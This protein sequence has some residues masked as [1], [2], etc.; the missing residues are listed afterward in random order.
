[1]GKIAFSRRVLLV[2][3]VALAGATDLNA[4][5]D[6]GGNNDA[7]RYCEFVATTIARTTGISRDYPTE[8]YNDCPADWWNA[9][10]VNKLAVDLNAD[11]VIKNGP[12][13]WVMDDLYSYQAVD[14]IIVV[15][16]LNLGLVA[17][18]ELDTSSGGGAT[19][20]PPYTQ[21]EVT[22]YT[23]YSFFAGTTTYRL[24]DPQGQ[25]Y[26]MQSYSVQKDT[27]LN[28]EGLLSL[29]D[30]IDPPD[31]WT[32]STKK[33][34]RD[35]YLCTN[36]LAHVIQDELGNSYQLIED[37]PCVLSAYYGA[38]ILP[39][40]I[41]RTW[42]P[43]A[44]AAG[45]L[46]GMPFALDQPIDP[47]EGYGGVKWALD[48]KLFRV[49]VGPHAETVTP[50]CATLQ[51]AIDGNE[52]KTVLLAGAFGLGGVNVPTEIEIVG[53]LKTVDGKSLNG[54]EIVSIAPFDAGSN[55]TFAEVYAA[56]GGE[57]ETSG[58]G[59]DAYCP[60]GRTAKAVKLTFSGGVRGANG[61]ALTDSPTALAAISVLATDA[62]GSRTVLTPFALRD[63]DNDNYLDAC[64]GSEVDGLR[65]KTVSVNSHTFY[66]LMNAP[67]QAA[68]VRI[69]K[70]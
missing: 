13:Y 30:V 33:L 49:T 47:G 65:L 17:S 59:D 27:S 34:D 24:T 31:G 12:R 66:S 8:G 21:S 53:D 43:G 64:F 61:G 6:Q 19:S 50:T 51:P 63:D 39:Q 7:D 20:T 14:E 18:V 4:A 69:E 3:M 46:G 35:F 41:D 40:G 42:C 2:G 48:P 55:L 37:E 62:A 28:R 57:I 16:G 10:N 60:R 67:N 54:L 23:K 38:A 36:G 26:V 25:V 5:A 11:Q 22:R 9:I 52:Q 68:A 56:D 58:P 29:G 1:M 70:R 15:D 32:Y 44:T 45:G